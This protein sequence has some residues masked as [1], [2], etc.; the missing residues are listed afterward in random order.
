MSESTNLQKQR[1]DWRRKSWTIPDLKR[2]KSAWFSIVKDLVF[3]IGAGQ[4]ANL[5]D[6]NIPDSQSWRLHAN[7]LRWT[8]LVNNQSGAL[9]LSDAG[10]KFQ[11]NPTLRYLADIIQDRTR[12]F[13]EVLDILASAPSTV[14]VVNE[15][16]CRAYG[17]KWTNLSNIRKRM[18]W[19]EVLGLI[20]GVGNRKWGATTAGTTAL[21]AWH[22]IS[23]DA[24]ESFDYDTGDVEIVEPPAE[25]A[26]LLQNLAESPEAHLKRN[27]YNIWVPSPNRI[28]N[29]RRIMQAASERITRTDLF[30]FIEN[31][32]DLKSSSVESMMPFL[33]A[34]GLL[35]E[36]G[37]GVYLTTAV[38]NAWLETGNDLD[39]IRILHVNMRF[40][41]E[42]IEVSQNTIV[43]NN[44]YSMAKSYGL[45]TEKARWIAG[46]LLEAGLLE[47]PQYL[48]L[49]ATPTGICFASSLPLASKPIEEPITNH[50]CETNNNATA[51][52][53]CEIDQILNN[54]VQSSRNPVADNK[55]SGVAFEEAIARTFRFMGF[56]S[57]RI[58][59]AGNTDV[60]VRWRKHDGTIITAIVDAKSKS[61]GQVTHSDISDVAIDAHKDINNA[62]FVGIVG[63]GFNGDTI[64]KHARKKAFALIT[65]DELCVI[66]RASESIGLSPCEIGLIFAV[67][68]GLSQLDELITAK[69]RELEI[70]ST[71]IARLNQEQDTLGGLSSRDLYFM[72]RN[73]SVSPSIEELLNVIETLS[74]P[75]IGVL[76]ATDDAQKSQHTT[77]I[78]GDAKK[79]I[80]RLRAIANSIAKAMQN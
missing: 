68:N 63:P 62:D 35:D 65:V 78:L 42:M 58:G 74:K 76:R 44:L 77:Y 61:S 24:L 12:L 40:V 32:F 15:Q 54:L 55:A 13:G 51:P 47:E 60:I 29:L 49:K 20:E 69:Q 57:K 28:D 41:G 52:L 39:L 14:E 2:G 48:H 16:L 10:V 1:N 21:K 27:T 46:F 59:G 17:L 53:I 64:K 30:A 43:R 18:D 79:A 9:H 26:V 3:L 37:R 80:N 50:V 33:K 75:E 31:E 38:A 23:P 71:I 7:F 72:L 66:T 19:L 4:A 25:I 8:G 34:S 6:T 5:D 73:T 56:D 45:N 70:S 67:P 22:L 36:V 11:A